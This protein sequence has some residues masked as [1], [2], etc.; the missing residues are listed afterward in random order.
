MVKPFVSGNKSDAADARGIWTAV[1]QP[2]IKA[3]AL[4][5]E[6][7]QAVLAL[8]RM[9]EQ[10]VKFRT[11]QRFEGIAYGVRRSDAAG[12]CWTQAHLQHFS[13]SAE[14]FSRASG[15]FFSKWIRLVRKK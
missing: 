14:S 12:V 3:V 6:E 7:Q 11:A 2:G 10:L 9:R 4:K 8:H 15:C 5:S 13:P 1:Q